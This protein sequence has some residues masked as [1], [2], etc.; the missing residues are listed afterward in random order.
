MTN[1]QFEEL[2]T[3]IT[4]VILEKK[5]QEIIQ[6]EELK[7]TYG[8]T[9]IRKQHWHTLTED[10]VLRESSTIKLSKQSTKLWFQ[11]TTDKLLPLN[12]CPLYKELNWKTFR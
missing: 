12:L 4:Q 5:V 7:E 1:A 2:Q 8:G 11:E 9:D 10:I 6:E 3:Q